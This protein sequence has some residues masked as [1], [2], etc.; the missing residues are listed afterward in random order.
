LNLTQGGELIGWTLDDFM[1]TMR[2]GVTPSGHQLDDEYMPWKTIFQ[3]MTDEELEA[4]WLY[5][6]SLPPRE[7]GNR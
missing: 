1:T 2:T 5:L 4:I 7:F 3:Y 6:Q